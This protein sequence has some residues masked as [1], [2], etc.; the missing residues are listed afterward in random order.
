LTDFST[1]RRI[2]R[3]GTMSREGDLPSSLLSG[4][5]AES[6][7]SLLCHAGLPHRFTKLVSVL[8]FIADGGEP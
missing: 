1:H 4:V 2:F 3:I 7:F 8:F 5:K 6:H